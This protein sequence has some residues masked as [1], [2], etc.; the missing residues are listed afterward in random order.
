MSTTDEFLSHTAILWESLPLGCAFNL[1]VFVD[2]LARK[3]LNLH[4]H[5][6]RWKQFMRAKSRQ[7]C[8]QGKPVIGGSKLSSSYRA[9][10]IDVITVKH[11]NIVRP[12]SVDFR[13]L[14]TSVWQKSSRFYSDLRNASTLE[15]TLL[16]CHSSL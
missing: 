9:L 5:P 13:G 11:Q 12:L 3:Y 16:V 10:A 2:L 15:L 4:T 1:R 8:F 6:H 7:I 14:I